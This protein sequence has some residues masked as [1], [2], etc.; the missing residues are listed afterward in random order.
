[1]TGAIHEAGDTFSNLLPSLTPC[2]LG[3]LVK[4]IAFFMFMVYMCLLTSDTIPMK[5]DKC[6]YNFI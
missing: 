3:E 5:L 6:V 4:Q 2:F 1:M